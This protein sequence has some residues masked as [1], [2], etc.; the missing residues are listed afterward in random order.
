MKKRIQIFYSAH[1]NLYK[2]HDGYESMKKGIILQ[3]ICTNKED[4]PPTTSESGDMKN[5]DH[6]QKFV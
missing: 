5:Q 2:K 6:N 4:T 3:N 1:K